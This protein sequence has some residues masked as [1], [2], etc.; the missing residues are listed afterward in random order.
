MMLVN[1]KLNE[2]KEEFN[3]RSDFSRVPEIADSIEK[4][5][6]LQPIVLRKDGMSADEKTQFYI[7]V[8]GAQR[9]R[10]LKKLGHKETQARIIDSASSAEAQMAANLFR[11]DLN[12]LEKARGF[13]RLIKAYPAKY[14]EG[15]IA[16]TFGMKPRTVAAL[17]SVAK[18]IPQKFDAEISAH[19]GKIGIEELQVIAQVPDEIKVKLAERAGN[20]AISWELRS[21]A[22]ELDF[23][24][25]AVNTGALLASGKAFSVKFQGERESVYTTDAAVYKQ[26]K[27]LFEKKSKE[28][29]GAESRSDQKRRAAEAEAKNRKAK[30]RKAGREE[31]KKIFKA[32]VTRF[33]SKKITLE[34]MAA[35]GGDVCAWKL[36]S[37]AA[38]AFCAAMGVAEPKMGQYSF[39]LTRKSFSAIFAE[40]DA[41][42]L[43]RLHALL[44]VYNKYG[45]KSFEEQMVDRCEK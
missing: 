44:S 35:I 12:I 42:G 36:N 13:E 45:A 9:V 14:S 19:I 4:L 5:G 33:L 3:P 32:A 2:I 31:A 25:D 28:R 16:K 38:R 30:K 41:N 23:T 18:R 22:K 20:G 21:L 15:T 11:S 1:V 39:D 29:Y 27:E 7:L 17:V 43:V 8:D 34:D 6:L 40:L 10:A 37:N 26:A 24:G